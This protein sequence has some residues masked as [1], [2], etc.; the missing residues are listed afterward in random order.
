MQEIGQTIKGSMTSRP[1]LP[2]WDAGLARQEYAVSVLACG[3]QQWRYITPDHEDTVRKA[4][5]PNHS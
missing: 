5:C 4:H 3:C 1:G 2:A